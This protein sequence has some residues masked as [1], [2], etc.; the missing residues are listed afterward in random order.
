VG[1]G[2][3]RRGYRFCGIL[4]G[5]HRVVIRPYHKASHIRRIHFIHVSAL[6]VSHFCFWNTHFLDPLYVFL[7]LS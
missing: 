5:T 2:I 7:K 6:W 3:Y 4:D 1:D